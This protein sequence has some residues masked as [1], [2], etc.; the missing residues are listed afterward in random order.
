ML[1]RKAIQEMIIFALHQRGK[2]IREIEESGKKT[3]VDMSQLD[4][5]DKHVWHTRQNILAYVAKKM[6]LHSS[7]WGPY[8]KSSEYHNFL[9]LVIS[10]LIKKQILIRW[11]EDERYGIWRLVE[12]TPNVREPS[13]SIIKTQS[14]DSEHELSTEPTEDNMRQTFLSIITKGRKDNTYKFALARA[15]LDYCKENPS[16]QTRVHEI[17]Y[18]YLSSKFLK[19]YWHQECK[20]H[21]KQDFKT[22]SS[23][24][25][26]QAIRGVFGKNSPGDFALL[27]KTDI[28]KTENRILK[29]VFGNAR[30]KTSLVVPKFQK[31]L[32][33]Q[34]AEEKQ[35]FYTYSDE[36]NKIYLKPQA[37]E[38][39]SRNYGLLF[40]TVLAEWAKYLEKI[41]GSLPKLVAKIE[42]NDLQRGNLTEYRRMY[43]EHTDCCFYCGD[44]L[45]KGDIHVDH[46]I[47]WSYIFEDEAWNLVLACSGCNLKKSDSLP[48]SDFK[49]E[50]I[51]R[52]NR[53]RSNIS[54]LNISLNQLTRDK[55]WEYEFKNHYGN[56]IEYGFQPIKLTRG[57]C[58][59]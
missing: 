26:T 29:D 16:D 21:I 18:E 23:P 56:C 46:F 34:Y 59:R 49:K 38:F 33:G 45:E 1:P 8:R 4:F 22:K 12:Y 3:K 19:Y 10:K 50:L 27:D 9:D 28:Q 15:L 6:K 31:I 43:L 35:I 39:F 40:G 58:Q 14:E 2:T 44:K 51:L 30:N 41:N 48:K 11:N 47:P 53:K 5:Q 37:H 20:F 52:N 24:K 7:L 32:K 54:R 42:Q 13:T 25:V 36:D 55:G 17:S 57:K